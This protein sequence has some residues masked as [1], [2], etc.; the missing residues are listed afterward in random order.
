MRLLAAVLGD[1]SCLRAASACRHHLLSHSSAST[2]GRVRPEWDLEP[3]DRRHS[4]AD[5]GRKRRRRGHADA[6]STG[7]RGSVRRGI[8]PSP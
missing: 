3:R 2:R 8:V 6:R 1:W 4:L 5:R 7:D